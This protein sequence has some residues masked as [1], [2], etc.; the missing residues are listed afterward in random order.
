LWRT[1][2]SRVYANNPQSLQECKDNIRKEKANI[3]KQEFLPVPR[4]ISTRFEASSEVEGWHY[5]APLGNT[6]SG[7]A[8]EIRAINSWQREASYAKKPHATAAVL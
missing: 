7:T 5:E 2:N 6:V 1:T 8:R 4:N 3:S